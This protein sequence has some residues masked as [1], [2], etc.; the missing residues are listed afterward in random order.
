MNQNDKILND[1]R[2]YIDDA[3]NGEVFYIK[4]YVQQLN[5]L[6]IMRIWVNFLEM[7]QPNPDEDDRT[8]EELDNAITIQ[9][10]IISCLIKAE[11][12]QGAVI[13]KEKLRKTLAQ[14]KELIIVFLRILLSKILIT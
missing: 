6:D 12:P 10:E 13:D 11:N 1:I 5:E 8:R 7:L 3:Q 14:N 9:E 4:E 2:S